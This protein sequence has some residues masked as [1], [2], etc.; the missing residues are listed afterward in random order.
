MTEFELPLLILVSVGGGLGASLRYLVDG[1]TTQFV[2]SRNSAS[3]FP[4]GLLLVNATGS[5][6]TGLVS[7]LVLDEF[8]P[9]AWTTVMMLGVLGGYTTFSSVSNDTVRLMREGRVW[10]GVFNA[11]GTL[12]IATACALTGLLITR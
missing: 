10:V 5:F 2:S 1:V 4:W 12:L 8:A 7:G 3:V 6:V 9:Q 11:F